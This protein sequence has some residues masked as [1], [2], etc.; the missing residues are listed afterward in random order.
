MKRKELIELLLGIGDDDTVVNV[1][2]D[3]VDS[4]YDV[5]GV[6]PSINLFSR[7][8]EISIRMGN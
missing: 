4:E 3:D 2:V 6:E 5:V 8:K 7:E 1:Y